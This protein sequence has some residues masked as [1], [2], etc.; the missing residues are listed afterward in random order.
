MKDADCCSYKNVYRTGLTVNLRLVGVLFEDLSSVI[1][2]SELHVFSSKIVSNQW[3]LAQSVWYAR[4][5]INYV[6]SVQ[7]NRRLHGN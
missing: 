2:Q 6:F 5:N 3:I 7:A 4:K 1:T